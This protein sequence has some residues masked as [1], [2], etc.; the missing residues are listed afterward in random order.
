[1]KFFLIAFLLSSFH[2]ISAFAEDSAPVI[3]IYDITGSCD[4]VRLQSLSIKLVNDSM[5]CD[6]TDGNYNFSLKNLKKILFSVSSLMPASLSGERLQ[7]DLGKIMVFSI[8]GKL[9][10][11]EGQKEIDLKQLPRGLYII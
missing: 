7:K 3:L 9:V 8:D 6:N 11:N 10:S 4:S 2:C 5:F 1:M